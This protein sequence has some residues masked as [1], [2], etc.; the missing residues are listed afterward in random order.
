MIACVRMCSPGYQPIELHCCRAREQ[1]RARHAD[2][3]L[4]YSS[5][6]CNKSFS[7]FFFSFSRCSHCARVHALLL[8]HFTRTLYWWLQLI[9]A[10]QR[11][12]VYEWNLSCSFAPCSISF[13]AAS[14]H[15]HRNTHTLSSLSVSVYL[16]SHLL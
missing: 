11:Y 3:L 6:F 16:N 13:H 14:T 10:K 9:I 12:T 5:C 1:I 7:F 4:S 15:A 2:I 8:S